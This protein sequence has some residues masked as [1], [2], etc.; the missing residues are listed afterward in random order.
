[1]VK[2]LQSPAPAVPPAPPPS[3]SPEP[4]KKARRRPVY[5]ALWLSETEAAALSE[6]TTILE[7]RSGKIR[8]RSEY[9]RDAIRKFV[10]DVRLS[11][12]FTE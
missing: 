9:I 12:E 3:P 2:K 8:Q 6:A 10:R 11:N 4:P 7:T 5:V 1:M